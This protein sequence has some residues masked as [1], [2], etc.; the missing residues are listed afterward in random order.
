ME[1]GNLDYR[2]RRQSALQS[3]S[4]TNHHRS[5]RRW[6]EKIVYALLVLSTGVVL[7]YLGSASSMAYAK[8]VEA[9]TSNLRWSVILP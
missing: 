3:A 5:E 4:F 8:T 7:S 6:R 1:F 9:G 2:S